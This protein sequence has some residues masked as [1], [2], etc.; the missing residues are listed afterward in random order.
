M[1]GLR[2]LRIHRRA[3]QKQKFM[4]RL[5]WT[6]VS[7]VLLLGAAFKAMWRADTVL[8]TGSPPLMVHFI[9]PLNVLPQEA[10]HL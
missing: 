1:A 10:A 6:V 5:V 9:A 4:A 7:N 3:Y 2:L 8:F